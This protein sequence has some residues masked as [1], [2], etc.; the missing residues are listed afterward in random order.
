MNIKYNNNMSDILD[1]FYM[2]SVIPTITRPTRITHTNATLIDNIYVKGGKFDS[3]QYRVITTV[4]LDH[5]PT[6]IKAETFNFKHMKINDEIIRKIAARSQI[7][8]HFN[9]VHNLDNVNDAYEAFNTK[10]TDVR[11]TCTNKNSQDVP[12]VYHKRSMGNY[13]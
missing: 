6:I 10:F 9:N 2:L 3:M 1:V 4:I 12:Q 5:L 13:Y 11:R 8:I 7:T